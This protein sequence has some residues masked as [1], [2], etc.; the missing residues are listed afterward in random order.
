MRG[1]G[2]AARRERKRRKNNFL[3]ISFTYR[4]NFSTSPY[5]K[6]QP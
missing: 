4:N 1:R 3:K 5:K 2:M 6:N